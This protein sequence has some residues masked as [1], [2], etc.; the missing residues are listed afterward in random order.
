VVIKLGFRKFGAF[1]DTI[2][3]LAEFKIVKKRADVNMRLLERLLV[4]F[5]IEDC[6]SR[7]VGPSKIT[8]DHILLYRQVL[9]FTVRYSRSTSRLQ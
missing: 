2:D 1:L 7:G 8:D 6:V 9:L 4:R 5:E 3:R